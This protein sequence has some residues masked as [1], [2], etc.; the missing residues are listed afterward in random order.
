[1]SGDAFPDRRPQQPDEVLATGDV[2]GDMRAIDR[3]LKA[4]G[5]RLHWRC[6]RDGDDRRLFRLEVIGEH[7]LKTAVA[8]ATAAAQ[9][10]SKPLTRAE[11]DVL[12]WARVNRRV[13][14]GGRIWPSGAGLRTA[15]ALAVR[16]LLRDVSGKRTPGRYEITGAGLKALAAHEKAIGETVTVRS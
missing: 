10:K 6:R 11:A 13:Q 14:R 1:M 8:R 5:L 12:A 7:P 9:A 4:N 2:D 3:L 16:G 15:T